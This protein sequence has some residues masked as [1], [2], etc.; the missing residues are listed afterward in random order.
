MIVVVIVVV[1]EGVEGGERREGWKEGGEE[2]RGE[3]GG[4]EE[5]GWSGDTKPHHAAAPR[6]AT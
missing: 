5:G 2:G 1:M 4:R 3:E 6:R